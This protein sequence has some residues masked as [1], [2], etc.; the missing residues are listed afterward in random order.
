MNRFIVC[1][2]LLSIASNATAE[3]W[4]GWRGPASDGVAHGDFPVEWNKS[5]VA[6]SIKMETHGGSTPVV[7]GH[8]IF[9]T[10]IK[11]GK[12]T[13]V[14]LDNE[15]K[16][17]WQKQVG[18]QR[19][20][21]HKKAS[22]CNPSPVTDG[23]HVYVYFK[24]GD[25]ACFDL[26][27]RE[28]WKLNLQKEYGED[29]LWWDLGTSPVLTKKH[30]VIAVMQTGPSYLVALDK[31]SG[32]AA[33]KHDRNLEA[34]EEAA[35]SYSTP[36][37]TVR[38][39]VEMLVVL[40]ADHVT[41][42]NAE[43]GKELWRVGG[44]NPTQHKYFRSISSPVISGDMVIAPYARGKS[45]TAIRMDGKGDVTKSHIAWFKED[46]TSADVPSP[47]SKDGRVY[48]CTDAG[49]VCCLDAETGNELWTGQLPKSRHKY[50]ASPIVAG[51]HIYLVRE[52]ATTFVLK[53]GETYQLA[54][55]NKLNEFAV[56]TPV[57]TNGRI[58][59]RTNEF[60][61]CIK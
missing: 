47:A 11:D 42:H 45:L 28:I 25:V 35:Q 48:V 50:S 26:A 51:G 39:G 30:V 22:G 32:K 9:F 27:G 6:W 13:I 4:P 29:T 8:Q 12:N 21:K 33:W 54:A 61:Y 41:A 53:Q 36:V 5:D 3:N 16:P 18:E 10:A 17:L 31:E 59:L 19:P 37:V 57:L 52:D 58:L 55:T 23:K 20:G 49:K 38:N 24:S 44:L 14:C 43:D 56:A 46:G 1:L 2:S 15:G 40:G 34:P 60:L 7:W